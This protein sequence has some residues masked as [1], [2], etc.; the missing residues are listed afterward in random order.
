MKITPIKIAPAELNAFRAAASAEGL[1]LSEW[2]RRAARLR[3]ATR[4][5]RETLLRGRR[6][7]R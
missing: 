5:L 1:T 7:R 4:A 3:L 6:V 2:V